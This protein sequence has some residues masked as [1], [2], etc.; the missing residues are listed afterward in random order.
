MKI[1]RIAK[2]GVMLVVGV[3]SWTVLLTSAAVVV[4][5]GEI[6][7]LNSDGGRAE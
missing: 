4:V 5:V 7:D 2:T 6:F 1:V 3:V